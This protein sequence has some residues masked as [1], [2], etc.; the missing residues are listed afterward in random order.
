[1]DGHKG[2]NLFNELAMF[3]TTIVDFTLKRIQGRRVN[4]VSMGGG[5]YR[6]P[7]L[8]AARMTMDRVVDTVSW[9]DLVEIRA[10]IIEPQL[11]YVLRRFEY[12]LQRGWGCG[13][14]LIAILQVG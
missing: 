3:R 7:A 4:L 9:I 8:Q 10:S 2:L 12:A 13:H 1:M 5:C 11:A 6:S 14:S